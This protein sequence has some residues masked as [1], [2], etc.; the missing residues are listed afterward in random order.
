[1]KIVKV[2]PITFSIPFVAGGKGEGIMPTTWNTLDFCLV[3]IEA[4]NGL[5]GW[6]EGF[7]YFCNHSVAEMIKRSLAPLLLSKEIPDPQQFNKE[8]QHKM[9]LQGRSGV[10]FYAL[11]GVDIALWDLKA[12]AEGVSLSQLLGEKC[13]TSIPA[14]ASLVRY[15]DSDLVAQKS[16]EVL[17]KGFSDLKLHEITMPEIRKCREVVGHDN[18]MIVDVNCNWSI[19]FTREVIP[20]LLNLQTRWLEEPVFPPEDYHLLADIRKEG[21]PVATG[22]NACGIHSFTEMTRLQ[23][24]DFL[25]PSITK[26][27]GIS[28]FIEIMSYNRSHWKLPLM[29]HSPYFGPGY[30]ATLQIAA[31]EPRFDLFEYLYIEPEKWLFQNMPLPVDGVISI[32]DGIGLGEDPILSLI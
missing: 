4:D 7:G 29:P 1:M 5:V 19:D 6:G 30:L 14:Y 15:A 16:L 18:G 11:S 22:E 2:D 20:E 26:V 21:M 12:K 13:R 10:S 9:V 32:P 17:N 23:A 28:V 24:T 27:G 3:R 31:I 8:A 25:Q